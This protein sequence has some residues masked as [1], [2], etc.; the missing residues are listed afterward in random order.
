MWWRRDDDLYHNFVFRL[1]FKAKMFGESREA[2]S[3][4]WKSHQ[5]LLTCCYS[6]RVSQRLEKSSHPTVHMRVKVNICS[7]IEIMSFFCD[8]QFRKQMPYTKEDT[9]SPCNQGQLLCYWWSFCEANVSVF[10]LADIL[11]TRRQKKT[12]WGHQVE[13]IRKPKQI[14]VAFFFSFQFSY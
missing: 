13:V 2:K 6:N 14:K 7:L 11:R 12:D 1:T 3:T 4:I 5:R 8:S 10:C 9:C